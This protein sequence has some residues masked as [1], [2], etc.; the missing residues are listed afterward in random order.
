MAL[1]FDDDP[2]TVAKTFETNPFI[3]E[4]TFPS[5]RTLN[6]FAIIIGTSKV[7]IT[8][9]CFAEPDADPIEYRF[10]GQGTKIQPQLSFDLPQPAQA[11]V[12]QV[13][14]LD[15]TTSDQAKIHIWELDLR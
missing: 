8:L 11:Q 5:P 14:V 15:P 6:G 7:Q 2:Y 4:M 3:I 9:K 10:E 12:L 13:E 1:V